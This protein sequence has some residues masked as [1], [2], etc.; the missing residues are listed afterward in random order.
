MQN[1]L[2]FCT[3]K[4]KTETSY[5]MKVQVPLYIRNLESQ[6]YHNDL[7]KYKEE[8]KIKLNA[9]KSQYMVYNC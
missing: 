3:Q 7:S 4:Q 2:P 9:G 1:K 5:K 6:N 8:E